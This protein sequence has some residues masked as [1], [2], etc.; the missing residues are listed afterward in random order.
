MRIALDAMG[1]DYAPRETILGAIQAHKEYGIDVILT[2]PEETIQ[3][4]LANLSA[5]MGGLSICHCSQ[6]IGMDESPTEAVR[7]KGNSSIVVG[8][9][10]VKRGEAAAF[11]SAGNSGA[12][13][14]AS[15]LNL[16]RIRGIERPAIGTVYQTETTPSILLDAG[17]NVECKPSYLVQFA[18]M[19]ASYMKKVFQV[20][21]PRVAILSNGS[22]EGKGTALTKESYSLLRES[23]LNFTG[24]IEG[25]DIF[26]GVVDVVVTDGF[27]GNV[28]LKVAEGVGQAI[29][30]SILEAI[31]SRPQYKLGALLLRPALKSVVKKLDYAEL[32]GAP[33]LGINGI[34]MIAHGR[35]NAKAIKNALLEARQCAE[36]DI[37]MAMSSLS[38]L[39]PR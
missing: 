3:K 25:Q 15:V 1:G 22:E 23:G 21:S 5:S 19:G 2:G 6:V 17:A 7:Q 32:G 26:K 33:L 12:I 11:V 35:S 18:H 27:T 13:M 10:L 37:I 36:K 39:S 34:V 38:A 14:A 24:H 28:A 4:E 30:N 16:G 8:L 31:A 29:I 20:S 9:D